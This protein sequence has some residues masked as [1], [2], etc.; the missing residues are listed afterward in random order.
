MSF[1]IKY[2]ASRAADIVGNVDPV[3]F[4]GAAALRVLTATCQR[5][6]DDAAAAPG[7]TAGA[8]SPRIPA[9]ATQGGGNPRRSRPVDAC[10]GIRP[11][12][13][14]DE[15]AEGA[16]SSVAAGV[17]CAVAGSDADGH[18][19]VLEALARGCALRRP[20]DWDA[21]LTSTAASGAPM[22]IDGVACTALPEPDQRVLLT[23]VELQRLASAVSSRH[24]VAS[25]T[26][27]QTLF[28]K[29]TERLYRQRVAFVNAMVTA[30][31]SGGDSVV[32]GP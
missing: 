18:S 5:D 26:D 12:R 9:A 6:D 25:R 3:V 28:D 16:A 27:S 14:V 10:F 11:G 24:P 8:S 21:T 20:R 7:V 13:T 30:R 29:I 15:E 2:N 32:Q 31:R 19:S 22:M 17:R 23:A 1:N 4:A